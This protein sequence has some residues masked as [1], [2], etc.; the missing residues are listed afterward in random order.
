MHEGVD[1]GTPSPDVGQARQDTADSEMKLQIS[2]SV[3]S[4]CK[5]IVPSC[6]P[7][8]PMA[9]GTEGNMTARTS[10][11]GPTGCVA[12]DEPIEVNIKPK[13]TTVDLSEDGVY[14]G[15]IVD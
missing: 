2:S 9:A 14:P 8:S 5:T 10:K 4:V 12:K 13:E 1:C 11:P 3:V 6:T 15:Q 7:N